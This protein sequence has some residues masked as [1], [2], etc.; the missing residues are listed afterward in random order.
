MWFFRERK[1]E[2]VPAAGYTQ[3]SPADGMW[4]I[5]LPMKKRDIGKQGE[6]LAKRISQAKLGDNMRAIF[7]EEVYEVQVRGPPPIRRFCHILT[8]TPSPRRENMY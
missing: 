2:P 4:T 8:R 3:K 1:P 6:V 5:D 7:G